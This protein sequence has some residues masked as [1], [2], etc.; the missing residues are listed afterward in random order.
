MDPEDLESLLRKSPEVVD[1]ESLE[2][3][4]IDIEAD[5]PPS[6]VDD[7]SFLLDFRFEARF[8]VVV[9]DLVDLRLLPLLVDRPC[10]LA[11]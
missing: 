5:S 4:S 11:T 2:R 3:T 1:L 10:F 9:V 6:T 8:L 7:T